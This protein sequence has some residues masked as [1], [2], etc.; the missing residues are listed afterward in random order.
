MKTI[1]TCP[2]C[3]L[4]VAVDTERSAG[5]PVLCPRC[6]NPVNVRPAMSGFILESLDGIIPPT[7]LHPGDN[8][9]GRQSDKSHA[10]I[11]VPD[12]TRNLSKSHATIT[13]SSNEATIR[14]AGSLNG[15][16]VNNQRLIGISQAKLRSGD[17]IRLGNKEFIIRIS[18]G[19]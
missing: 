19:K 4:Q 10:E 12:P 3:G 13:V 6:E 8:S 14:D 17:K 18:K 5:A 11:Q 16:F 15:T 9:I 1:E 7:P 2:Q